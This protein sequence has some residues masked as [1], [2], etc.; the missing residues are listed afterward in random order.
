MEVQNK[1]Q[2]RF[3]MNKVSRLV[4]PFLLV[5]LLAGSWLCLPIPAAA[6][7]F[8]SGPV[9]TGH[10]KLLVRVG[11][12]PIGNPGPSCSEF[13]DHALLLWVN[14]D[15]GW[16]PSPEYVQN[17]FQRGWA[18][19]QQNISYNN[20]TYT[21]YKYQTCPSGDDPW[22]PLQVDSSTLD[23]QL[24]PSSFS[25]WE[26]TTQVKKQDLQ[27]YIDHYFNYWVQQ[28]GGGW[29]VNTNWDGTPGSGAVLL[30]NGYVATV[31]M[32][33]SSCADAAIDN[34]P[35]CKYPNL[36]LE[37]PKFGSY[38]YLGGLFAG[39]VPQYYGSERVEGQTAP[40]L[41]GTG[42]SLLKFHYPEGFPTS[43][44]SA[45]LVLA[46]RASPHAAVNTNGEKGI[47]VWCLPNVSGSINWLEHEV[48]WA[49]MQTLNLDHHLDR[50][51]RLGSTKDLVPSSIHLD[52]LQPDGF[53]SDY[54]SDGRLIMRSE[55]GTHANRYGLPLNTASV[56]VVM[57]V[58]GGLTSRWQPQGQYL[59]LVVAL[60]QEETSLHSADPYGWYYFISK[61][62]GSGV[63]GSNC[64]RLWFVYRYPQ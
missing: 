63:N 49:L 29:Q 32:L 42:R 21:L 15:S 6:Q 62:Y 52:R 48:T 3:V 5:W 38:R 24:I 34:R 53:A 11:L 7:T 2:N 19:L 44:E 39:Q 31:P 45:C 4:R 33:A 43:I 51:E 47:G 59:G 36:G 14:D 56:P 30:F 28:P 61:D 58:Y 64:P 18:L 10:K 46:Y 26:T 50:V 60:D 23:I 13:P 16:R 8:T 1:I 22:A 12:N 9:Y 37:Y 57:P 27:L 17:P 40:D 41:S 35:I 55:L 25:D 20:K 54:R